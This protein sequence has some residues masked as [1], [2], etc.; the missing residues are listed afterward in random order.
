VAQSSALKVGVYSHASDLGLLGRAAKERAHP[1]QLAIGEGEEE[2][3]TGVEVGGGYVAE[4]VLPWAM[5]AM[6]AGVVERGVVQLPHGLRVTASKL[7]QLEHS[8]ILPDRL[9]RSNDDYQRDD[10]QCP[11]SAVPGR[12]TKAAQLG[13]GGSC[14]SRDLVVDDDVA[15]LRRI[16]TVKIRRARDGDVPSIADIHVRSWQAAYRG[17]LPDEL[18]DSLSVSERERSWGALLSENEDRWLTLVA[19]HDGGDLAG[20]CSVATP[21]RDADADGLTAEVGA[22]YVDPGYWRQGA[23]SAMLVVALDELHERG[24]REVILWVLPE[25]QAA[26][27]F[28]ARFGFAV[29][30]GVEKREERS[31]RPVIRLRAVVAD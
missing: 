25:N 14:R 8:R 12:L 28:Y 6:H 5:A 9:G 31:G 11:G 10:P 1:H 21:S 17:V 23:G 13:C 7:A 26:L 29:E 24:W 2:V 4:V 22:F 19:E 15:T 27:A 30:E 3:A 16:S 20:F 18:L